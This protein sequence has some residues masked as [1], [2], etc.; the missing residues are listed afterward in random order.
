MRIKNILI[1]AAAL[2]AGCSW[3][4]ESPP[5]RVPAERVFLMYDNIGSWFN[6]DV[7][8]AGMAVAAGAIGPRDRVVVFHRDFRPSPGDVRTSY[9]YELVKDGSAAGG[10]RR[11]ILKRYNQ[12]ENVSLSKEVIASVVNDIRVAVPA[13]HYGLAFG[14]HGMG[15]LPKSVNSI[16]RAGDT[17]GKPFEHPFA[18]LWAERENPLTRY[19]AGYGEKLDVS[20]FIDG[21]D[22]WK[23]DFI[24]LDDCFMA[25][26]E[27]MYEMRNLA[28]YI[29]ASPTEILQ[30]G[31]PYDRVVK[32]IFDDWTVTGFGR[33]GQE[34]VDY[35]GSRSSYPYGTIAVVDMSTMEAFATTVKSLNMKFNE[36]N[37]D[38]E[39]IQYYEGISAGHVFWDMDDYLIHAR[40]ETNPAGYNAFKAQ[41]EQTVVFAGHTS[42]YYTNAFT[43]QGPKPINHF[44]G[45]NVFIPWSRTSSLFEE[46]RQTEWYKYVYAE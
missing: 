11:E 37:P 24:I 36:L 1:F 5:E 12:G 25:S 45:L 27:A 19:F 32:T 39:N 15:W 9:V 8:E 46:Y 33:V 17:P 22:E 26:A 20:E 14:S 10:F 30:D 2:L 21:L 44:S 23:W 6:G 31:F 4:I 41:L 34:F 43:S 35:Y 38:A 3:D 29:I 7:T 28:S 13:E 16:S 40:A 18:E 42:E